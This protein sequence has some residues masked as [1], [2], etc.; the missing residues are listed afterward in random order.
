[1]PD[2]HDLA[3]TVDADSAWH[4]FTRVARQRHARRRRAAAL[5][6]VAVVVAGIAAAYL[7]TQSTGRRVE[8]QTSP[9]VPRSTTRSPTC[10]PSQLTAT[11][12]FV[13]NSSGAL[14]GVVLT[15]H[16]ASACSLHG[17]PDVRVLTRGGRYLSVRPD[18]GPAGNTPPTP[19]NQPVVLTARAR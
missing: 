12:G 16:A 9:T 15:N 6:I 8:I 14:G 7:G 10:A 13:N 5:A 1:M 3:P 17:R 4:I 11:F 19:S 18:S 2:L